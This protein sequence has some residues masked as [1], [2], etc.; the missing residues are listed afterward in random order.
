MVCCLNPDCQ[1]PLNQDTHKYCQSCGTELIPFLRNRF[2]II[3]P[4][5]RGGFGKTYLAEDTDKLKEPCVVKQLVYQA[6]GSHANKLIVDLFMR[7]AEQLQQ[8]WANPQVPSLFAYFEE[9]GYL[10]LVQQYIEGQDL[11]QEL[12]QHGCFSDT[13]ILALLQDLL[14]VFSAIH[15]RNVIHRDIKPE[16]IM[17]RGSD[18][19]LILIDFGVSKQLSQSIVS[20]AGTMVGS[21]GYAAPEQMESGI[22]HPNSD[23]YSLGASCFH[24][25][26]G[27]NP[28]SLWRK[29]GYGW[30]EQ[31]RAQLQQ[32]ICP[33][34]GTVLDKLLQLEVADRYQSAEAA[35]ADLNQ[36]KT[37]A[38]AENLQRYEAEFRKAV[39]S[40]YPL[41]AY[42]RD[43][44][45]QFQKT[46]GLMD[47]E[48]ARIEQPILV[49]AEAERQEQLRQ[50]V[51]AKRQQSQQQ[52]ASPSPVPIPPTIYVLPT[53]RFEFETSTLV[54]LEK[55]GLFRKASWR[56]Q[57]SRQT[58][59]F[60]AEDL[61]N[62]ITLDM[63]GIPAG[64]FTMG[65]PASEPQRNSDEDPQHKV[66]VPAFYL[67]KYEI[68]QGQW[69]EIMGSNPSN[70]KGVKR[71]VEQVSWEDAVAFC[72]KL[73]QKTG[74]EY[75]L[76][77]EAEWEYA[78][79]AGTSTPFHFGSTITPDLANYRGTDWEY[80]GT[81]YPGNYG[82]GPKG[83]FR[84]QTTEV[85]SFPP[86]GFGLYDM[87]GNVWE[88]CKDTWHDNYT[89]APTDGSAWIDNDND[90]RILRGGSWDIN[91]RYCRCADR[92]R[93]IPGDRLVND[94]FRV[95]L[96]AP[97]TLP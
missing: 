80:Q 16:N 15:D 17:R 7:E 66:N 85:D 64:Q 26:T 95:A 50:Q 5:G 20:I 78:C 49:Q 27:I 9:G 69:Q 86:N 90:S 45:Q 28:W 29:Q 38:V 51:E 81:T 77:S 37:Q 24:L 57:Y 83:K 40:A 32:P 65:S 34:L 94:G 21:L 60:F 8:F 14:P 87:H 76:P 97:R 13:K 73:S 44:L 19:R 75:R 79:R 11:L 70:F 10:Y 62:S 33:E 72:Q 4:L 31:W 58:A 67:G 84:E 55:G 47:A 74:R 18:G 96:S 3:K 89:G 88:W 63:V 59:E 1:K 68:T 61:G 2:K 6:Q 23:L 30:L 53:Q 56:V 52:P 71:P 22:A 43:G 93:S 42:V 39:G 82:S 54:L 25:M 91:P 36:S 41:D 46:L 48:I 12:E 35:L 92:D